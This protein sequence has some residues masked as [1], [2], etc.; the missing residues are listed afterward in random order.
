MGLKWFFV[1]SDAKACAG[2]GGVLDGELLFFHKREIL[3]KGNKLTDTEHGLNDK[4]RVTK[5]LI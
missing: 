2:D 1:L 3:L 4:A 5:P